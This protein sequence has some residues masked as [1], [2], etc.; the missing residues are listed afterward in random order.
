MPGCVKTFSTGFG[1][2]LL[3]GR[4]ALFTASFTQRVCYQP[5][6]FHPG[7]VACLALFYPGLCPGPRIRVTSSRRSWGLTRP[8]TVGGCTLY[9][10]FYQHSHAHLFPQHREKKGL[11]GPTFLSSIKILRERSNV[12]G[13]NLLFASTGRAV[14]PCQRLRIQSLDE[15]KQN[16]WEHRPICLLSCALFSP[17]PAIFSLSPFGRFFVSRRDPLLRGCWIGSAPVA[18]AA[19]IAAAAIAGAGAAANS[20]CEQIFR[21]NESCCCER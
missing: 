6:H 14:P 19:A 8:G 12:G 7:V 13:V 2:C 15:S 4:K 3:V 17:P 10:E 20:T 11:D 18:P 5:P 9:F 1:T 16:I 21:A